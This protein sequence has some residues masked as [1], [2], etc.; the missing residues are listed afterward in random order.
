MHNIYIFLY[1]ILVQ[2]YIF[3]CTTEGR[4]LRHTI[5]LVFFVSGKFIAD[6][7]TQLRRNKRIFIAR[8]FSF[9][10]DYFLYDDWQA[11]SK[12]MVTERI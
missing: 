4:K 1:F 2:G 10:V 12:Q 7:A 8:V 5:F 6:A 9:G 3:W 11:G